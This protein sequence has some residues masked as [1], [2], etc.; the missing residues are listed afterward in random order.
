MRILQENIHSPTFFEKIFAPD[1]NFIGRIFI[2]PYSL[3]KCS[4]LMRI[5]RENI[6]SPIFFEN[7]FA[8]DETFTHTCRI[9]LKVCLKLVRFFSHTN[10]FGEV[11]DKVMSK[12]Q[13]FFR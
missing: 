4:L 2:H 3:K 7:F 5:I 10:D 1:E 9:E 13:N 8:P 6:H 11:Y 12:S